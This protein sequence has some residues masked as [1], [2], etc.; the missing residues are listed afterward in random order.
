[1]ISQACLRAEALAKEGRLQSRLPAV[2]SRHAVA[3]REGWLRGGGS[4]LLTS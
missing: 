4:L 2:A 3:L 1:M